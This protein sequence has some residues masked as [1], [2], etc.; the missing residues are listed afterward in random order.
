MPYQDYIIDEL[1]LSGTVTSDRPHH[2]L[3]IV[4]PDIT[5]NRSVPLL[6]GTNILKVAIDDVR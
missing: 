1:E 4:V 6:I 3:L 2:C 5:Y